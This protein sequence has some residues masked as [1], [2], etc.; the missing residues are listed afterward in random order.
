MT[1][2]DSN[3]PFDWMAAGAALGPTLTKYS[4]LVVIGRDPVATGLVAVGIAHAQSRVRSV[5]IGDLFA[6]SPPLRALVDDDDPHG[7]VD[8]FQFGVSLNKIAR[9]VA[10]AGELYILPSGS[11]EPVY[12]E[13]LSN[14]RWRRLAA[15]FHERGSLLLLAAPADAARLE[16]LVAAT[17]GVVLVGDAMPSNV[18]AVSVVA[19]VREPERALAGAFESSEPD[20]ERQPVTAIVPP[21]A[22]R[23]GGQRRYAPIAGLC[24]AV[25]LALV[26]LWLAYRPL[27]DS[28]T[29]VPNPSGKG[30]LGKVLRAP[31][32]SGGDSLAGSTYVANG[33]VAAPAVFNPA[34]SANAAAY[35]VQLTNANMQAGAILKLQ[36]DG[37]SLPAETFAPVLVNGRTWY[38]VIT[39]ASTDSAG[40]DSLL[41]VLGR[42]HLLVGG[43]HVVRVPL[44]FRI[45]EVSSDTAATNMIASYVERGEPVY[46]LRQANGEI[47]LLVGAFE[48]TE[49][50]SLYAPS[51]RASGV[52]PVLV[53][54]TGRP[55]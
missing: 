21:R 19:N 29:P 25:A 43:E 14:P 12:E 37:K 52:A 47:W 32:A 36:Q 3:P 5:A 15:G 13:L 46:A 38:R 51:L 39:G 10:D 4:A 49:Q 6:D 11:H 45:D 41:S 26:G 7:L 40:A 31:V 42:R 8:C 48:S 33:A 30:D 54:R 55:F 20:A 44:A 34:D 35:A 2:V 27:A 24:A 16:D 23:T 17:D 22:E 53:Y 50:A 1:T 9:R 18:R 28:R